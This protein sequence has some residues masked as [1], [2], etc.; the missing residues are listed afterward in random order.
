MS[1]YILWN[2]NTQK[3]LSFTLFLDMWGIWLKGNARHFPPVHI[4]IYVSFPN[5]ILS[6]VSH[7]FNRSLIYLGGRHQMQF[8]QYHLN[9][10]AQ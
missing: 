2:K 3:C 9:T 4:G 10:E 1:A 5:Y 6:A 7:L 8:C